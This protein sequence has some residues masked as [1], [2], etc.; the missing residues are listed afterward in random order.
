[1]GVAII[2]LEQMYPWPEAE[3]QAALD[4]HPDAQE[5]VWVQ[6]EPR[7]MGAWRFMFGYFKGLNRVI[8][9]AGR[10]KN[11]SPAAGSAKRHAE[12]QKRL[13][14]DALK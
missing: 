10:M 14:E 6:E 1:M 4:Q 12:E 5:I 11:A 8:H 7:N 2:F 9:Y 13:I 3:L